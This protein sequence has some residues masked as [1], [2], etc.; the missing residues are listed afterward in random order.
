MTKIAIGCLV[1]WYEAGIVDS[2]FSTLYEAAN[3][4]KNETGKQLTID[5]CLCKTTQLEEPI[6]DMVWT[7]MVTNIMNL[8]HNYHF[9]LQE[10]DELYTIADYRR[11]FNAKYCDTHDVLVWGESDMLVPESM[12][13]AI[14]SLHAS[15][16]HLTPKYIATFASCKMWD[17]TW[18]QLE[19][20]DF[21][22]KP[23]SDDPKD[24][25]GVRYTNTIQ[26]MHRI[27]DAH[28][29]TDIT[30]I[31]PLK[32]NGCG[33]TISSEIIKAGVNIPSSV[34]FVHEDTAF[35]N[36]LSKLIPETTQYHF[37]HIYLPHNRKHPNK[38]TGIK[39]ED[40]IDKHDIG[41]L[42]KSHWWYEKA[43]RYSEM[44]AYNLFNPNFKFKTWS[45]VFNERP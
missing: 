2:Y 30:T 10:S 35:L 24:W 22:S 18:S 45:D 37:E 25:W 20:P 27:N 4:Y 36:V 43:N 41:K 12:F 7:D 31:A 21:R 14:D 19:H 42:R 26:D 23:H 32:F 38:R 11:D 17:I 33:L 39:G 40:G 15:V 9:K 3:L 16:A 28:E 29:T 34:F 6:N 13:V 8:G 5:I 44:N 1:Q